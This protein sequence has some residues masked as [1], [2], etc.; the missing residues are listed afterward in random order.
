[1]VKEFQKRLEKSSRPIPSIFLRFRNCNC[2]QLRLDSKLNVQRL[3]INSY[4]LD[5]LCLDSVIRF[6]IFTFT[7]AS[8]AR[9]R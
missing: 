2:H 9:T 6:T 5:S 8:C 3:L 7:F 1:M 4:D